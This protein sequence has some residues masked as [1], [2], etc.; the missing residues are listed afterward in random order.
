MARTA[1]LLNRKKELQ[2]A[3]SMAGGATAVMVVEC[4][5]GV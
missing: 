3:A 4:E 1:S 5:A 2:S